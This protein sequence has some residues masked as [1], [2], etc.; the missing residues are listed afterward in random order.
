LAP[1]KN[2]LAGLPM[3]GPPAH[4]RIRGMI[5]IT[6][7]ELQDQTAGALVDATDGLVKAT[8]KLVFATWGLVG[9]TLVLVAAVVV[10]KLLGRA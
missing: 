9:S 6:V 7:A 3:P 2:D 1:L 8:S 5:Q 10:L 4:G